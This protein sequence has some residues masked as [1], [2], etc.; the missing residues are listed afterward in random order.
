MNASIRRADG[1]PGAGRRGRRAVGTLLAV[2]LVGT[3]CLGSWAH[4]Q[5]TDT[6][7]PTIRHDPNEVTEVPAGETRPIKA[8]VTDEGSKVASVRLNLFPEGDYAMR[9]EPVG[10]DDYFGDRSAKELK[11]GDEIRYWITATDGA[12]NEQSRGFKFDPFVVRVGERVPTEPVAEADG[13]TNWL[14]IAGAAVSVAVLAAVAGGGG[15]GGDDDRVND[16]CCGFVIE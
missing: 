11:P 14:L 16:L 5:E 3:Q 13:G 7:P 10:G 15:G 8:T 4:A 12:G 6:R 9:A 1:P 2:A